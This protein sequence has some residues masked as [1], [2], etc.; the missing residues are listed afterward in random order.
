MLLKCAKGE[1]YLEEFET[2]TEF[3]GSDIN[4]DDLKTQLLT[5]KLQFRDKKVEFQDIIDTMKKP[6]VS[7]LLPE[8]ATV[9]K[10]ILVLPATNSQSERVFS[11]LRWVKT[12]LRNSMK[13][14]RLNHV[15]IL[16]IYEQ[17]TKDL[18]L[19][20]VADEFVS[21]NEQRRSDFGLIQNISN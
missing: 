2:V 8:I 7:D 19:D 12:Y 17:I 14:E 11:N 1:D 10:L 9:V 3:Y 5:F 13:Q 16:N 6:N 21:Q 15:M 4:K 20:E 18:N